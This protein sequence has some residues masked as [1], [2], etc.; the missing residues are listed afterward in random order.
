MKSSAGYVLAAFILAALAGLVAVGATL[1]RQ[2]AAAQTRLA[3]ADLVGAERR[4]R[5]IERRLNAGRWLAPV[6]TG[7]QDEVAAHRA[8]IRYW[9]GDYA[10]LL[11]DYA[12]NADARVRRNVALRITVANAAYRAG[13]RPD[14]TVGEML[15]SLDHAID[16]YAE[17]LQD[18]G[19]R[20]DLA[21]NYEFL[22]TLRNALGTGARWTPRSSENP[23]GQEGGQ[24]LTEDTDLD[25]VEIFVPMY[26]DDRDLTDEPTRGTDPPIERR[27]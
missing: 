8:A 11:S 21:F 27:G 18:V 10:R 6:L 3:V 15:N 25:D 14:A 16:L 26:H 23:L 1:E 13:Q 19:E 22:V 4:F 17:L 5:E 7:P 24:P 2:L 9:R 12:R 20:R